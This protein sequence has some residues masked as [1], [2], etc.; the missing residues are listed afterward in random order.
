MGWDVPD[1]HYFDVPP[2][3]CDSYEIPEIEITSRYGPDDEA[4]QEDSEPTQELPLQEDGN[5]DTSINFD[6]P[7]PPPGSRLGGEADDSWFNP[8]SLIEP[9]QQTREA[10]DDALF[11]L[12]QAEDPREKTTRTASSICV[13]E[14][15]GGASAQIYCTTQE[16]AIG[17][18]QPR[19]SYTISVGITAKDATAAD[20]PEAVPN[21]HFANGEV[22]SYHMSDQQYT[23]TLDSLRESIPDATWEWVNSLIQVAGTPQDKNKT[24]DKIHELLETAPE[25][26]SVSR[27]TSSN[28]KLFCNDSS[29][30]TVQHLE[31]NP[32]YIRSITGDLIANH[33]TL[34]D[35]TQTK[36][37]YLSFTDG[38]EL[39]FVETGDADEMARLSQQG[40]PVFRPSTALFTAD[41]RRLGV[42]RPTELLTQIFT[43]KI[44][45][46]IQ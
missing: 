5:R 31:A 17:S 27:A 10:F 13:I 16:Q 42:Q 14:G 15:R 43:E 22:S 24:I 21:R 3:D 26:I 2:D 12:Q 18:F 28:K 46:A 44:R 32:P 40:I 9:H 45:Q 33:I 38:T 4:Y 37:I 1:I 29:V 25:G 41:H 8:D 11:A 30:I 39:M 34:R 35:E 20:D 7:K 23:D 6:P 36:Y 19:T